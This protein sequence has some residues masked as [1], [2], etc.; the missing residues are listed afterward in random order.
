MLNS[1]ITV[2]SRRKEIVELAANKAL[3]LTLLPSGFWFHQDIRD[4]FYYAIHLFAY[5][6]DKEFEC[7][8]NVEQCKKGKEI[9]LDMIMRVLL[10]QEKN[11]QDS[12]YGHWPLNLGSNPAAAKPHPLPVE[13][14]G[15][16]L[17]LFHNKYQT[18]L[19]REVNHYCSQAI[20][21]IY[22]SNVY[23]QPLKH[24]NHHESKHTSLKLLLGHLF[25]DLK[26]LEEGLQ[27][28][29]YMLQHIKQFGFKEYGALPW[30]FHWIQSF[31]CVWEVVEHSEVRT[32]MNDL[33]EH[34]W[35]LR[36]DYYLKGTWAGPHSRQWPHDAPK[37]K[38]TLLDYIQFGD[39][40]L[41]NEI[42]RLEGSALFTYKVA[43]EIVQDSV[44]RTKPEE[45]MRKIQ[46]ANVD[47]NV[48]KEVHTYVYIEP[49]FA[50]GGIYERVNEFDNEQHRWDITLPLTEGTAN[51]VNQAF[52]FHPGE[53]YILGDERH[54][55]SFGEVMFY[56]NMV[57]QLW[58]VPEGD[59]EVFPSI[60]GCLPKGEWIFEDVSGYG[61]AGDSYI[62]FQLMNKYNIEERKDR[63]SITS[64][65]TS[66]WNGVIMEA[67]SCKNALSLGIVSLDAFILAMKEKN[68]ACFSHAC[69]LTDSTDKLTAVYTTLCNDVIEFSVDRLGNIERLIN[70]GKH[71]FSGYKI[72]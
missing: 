62:T 72:K 15:C 60:A 38:N 17:I 57:M 21:N 32:A 55:S 25:N 48:E 44:N 49:D 61:R 41:P 20:L 51:S 19:P 13:L 22:K 37:D 23:R 28:A 68:Q 18:E 33:L 8:W 63:H 29:N 14:M 35:K 1:T 24:M 5:C 58:P 56:K 65:F 43:D 7:S 42:V 71:S 36:A 54:E 10:L 69:S 12:M 30:Y 9:A 3:E 31:T 53:K 6:T 26:L 67:V 50:V 46:F 52:F 4:N 39:F 47:G 66:G 2:N 64:Q 70:G 27:S 59:Q 34:L 11:P 40:P 16:L 45:I